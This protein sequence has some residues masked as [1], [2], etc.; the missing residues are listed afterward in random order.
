MAQQLRST[1]VEMLDSVPS[2]HPQLLRIPIIGNPMPSS[3]FFGYI[4]IYDT[5]MMCKSSCRQT[6]TH[7][8]K[9]KNN[10]K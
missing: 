2:I 1:R 3:D 9:S 7:K 10:K 8:N 5:P 6:H 4:H